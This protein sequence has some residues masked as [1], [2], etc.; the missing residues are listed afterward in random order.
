MLVLRVGTTHRPI[1]VMRRRRPL[2]S[3]RDL[4]SLNRSAFLRLAGYPGRPAV[5]RARAIA[6][7]LWAAPIA[8][9][10]AALA[11][12]RTRQVRAHQARARGAD[13][14]RGRPV[15]P[16]DRA[17]PVHQQQDR[18][19]ARIERPEQAGR[20]RPGRS[21]GGRAPARCLRPCRTLGAGRLSGPPADLR[22]T[23]S[24]GRLASRCGAPP[25]SPTVELIPQRERDNP[26][27]RTRPADRDHPGVARS[28]RWHPAAGW[29]ATLSQPAQNG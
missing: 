6:D 5:Q 27:E 25:L 28:R 12:G 22:R 18:Q 2:R 24:P 8:E 23:G 20:Q 21:R 10:A 17:A 15:Q 14:A 19:R 1:A 29:R 16:R 3:A 9:E 11:A 13:P 4:L 7:R 26:G